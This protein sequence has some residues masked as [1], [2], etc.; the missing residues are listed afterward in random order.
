MAQ[1]GFD[2]EVPAPMA[3]HISNVLFNSK[4]RT[5]YHIDLYGGGESLNG[6]PAEFSVHQLQNDTCHALSQT[7]LRVTASSIHIDRE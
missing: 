4:R 3:Q 5:S 6:R 2:I 7:R 1:I